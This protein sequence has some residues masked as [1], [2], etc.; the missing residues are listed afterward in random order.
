MSVAQEA[1]HSLGVGSA[2]PA[3]A[4][5]RGW[6]V[7]RALLVA[8]L[9]GLV[10]AFVLAQL[11]YGP[12]TSASSL[13]RIGP[14]EEYF[15]FLATLPLWVLLA[16]AYRLYAN[17]E[18][19]T[20][21]STVDEVVGIFHL[22]TVGTFTVLVA[23][24]LTGVASPQVGKI[25]AFWLLGISLVSLGR[26]G[27]RT[28]CRRQPSYLQNAVIVGCGYVGQTV[29]R[30]FLNHPE[31]GVHVVGFLDAEPR[32]KSALVRHLP[33][34]GTT[35][36]LREVVQELRIDRVIFAFSSDSH[37]ETLELMRSMKD[38]DVQVD[39]VPRLFEM[40]TPTVQM[41]SVE[42]LPML[43]MPAMRLSRSDRSLKR[44][45]D[46]AL[47]VIGLIMLAPVF[48][49]AAVAIKLDSPGPVFFGQERIGARD[50]GFRM[51]KFRSMIA[52][53]EGRQAEIA[54]LNTYLRDGDQPIMFKAQNDPRVTRVGR[55]LRRTNIDELPQL[56]NVVSGEMSL[57]GSR[58]LI[59]AEDQAVGDWGRRRLDLKPGM[60]G[61]WQ[62]LGRNDI[63]FSEMVLLD[64][65]YV[66]TWTLRSDLALLWRTAAV[67]ARQASLS[68]G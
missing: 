26:A 22:V 43:S 49:L 65:Q 9:V 36:Q 13:D 21:H 28:V 64:Y 6:L 46:L 48:L 40:I 61:L 10:S 17:D 45:M 50:R 4:H 12:P 47:A 44:A 54:H 66:T 23:S 19:R 41:H 20:D 24:W 31:Y 59:P 15:T 16:K 34:L 27:A 57:V 55:F 58:P 38:L 8:D 60:T 33:V 32:D 29:A 35:R 63:P 51:W 56:M 53:A 1:V 62:V 11:A 67:V 68:T 37:E 30:K 52:D 14:Q 42:G 3:A 7:R 5:R 25:A 2:L 39:V 18:E